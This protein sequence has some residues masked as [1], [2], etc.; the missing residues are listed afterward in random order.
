MVTSSKKA[1]Y[2]QISN[3]H[4]CGYKPQGLGPRLLQ[5]PSNTSAIGSL[6]LFY[7]TFPTGLLTPPPNLDSS[8]T[9]HE[10]VASIL[11]CINIKFSYIPV[12][13][14]HYSRGL[15]EQRSGGRHVLRLLSHRI[16]D[17]YIL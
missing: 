17:L 13:Y 1:S 2:K 16:G 8:I 11:C 5:W 9:F 3:D 10:G 6:F 14:S 4:Q 12:V 7:S 15:Y